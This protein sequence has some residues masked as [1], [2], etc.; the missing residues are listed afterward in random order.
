MKTIYTIEN[1]PNYFHNHIER[2]TKAMAVTPN[3]EFN[4]RIMKNSV[5]LP[6]FIF[7]FIFIIALLDSMSKLII[8]LLLFQ[9]IYH[10]DNSLFF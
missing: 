4:T 6:G 7:Y 10:L 1:V 2:T 5:G 8:S 3:T 9:G